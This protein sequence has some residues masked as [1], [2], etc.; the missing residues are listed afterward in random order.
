M[1]PGNTSLWSCCWIKQADSQGET[2]SLPLHCSISLAR[3]VP[4]LLGS[5]AI[6]GSG[7][8]WNMGKIDEQRARIALGWSTNCGLTQDA[9]AEQHGISARTLREWRRRYAARLPGGISG[10]AASP[11]EG[12]RASIQNAIEALQAML[13]T[14]PPGSRPLPTGQPTGAGGASHSDTSA[15]CG[16]VPPPLIPTAA[17]QCQGPAAG[18]SGDGGEGGAALSRETAD[19]D[20]FGVGVEA[21]SGCRVAAGSCPPPGRN[22][23]PTGQLV[24]AGVASRS[25]S[26]DTC[27]PPPLLL[28]AAA[29]ASSG[30]NEDHRAGRA[31]RQAPLF[32]AAAVAERDVVEGPPAKSLS[33]ASHRASRPRLG[34]GFF[35]D[36]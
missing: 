19:I 15:T 10:V 34:R 30:D 22:P 18:D 28:A 17:A 36:M 32:A 5:V 7:N 23:L 6:V 2:C 31:E 9:Y 8:L 14:L 3:V 12:L 21:A 24:P 29:P 16:D 1:P 4:G 11:G 27:V 26:S 25:D 33:D 20:S 35:D 13:E